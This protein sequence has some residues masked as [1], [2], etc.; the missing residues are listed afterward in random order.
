MSHNLVTFF[1]ANDI[2]KLIQT[3]NPIVPLFTFAQLLP[4]REQ[5]C[6]VVTQT[7]TNTPVLIHHSQNDQFFTLYTS[8][9]A[10]HTLPLSLSRSRFEDFF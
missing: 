7:H 6:I 9:T 4:N 1:K 3:S 5:N 2:F 8:S 10:T